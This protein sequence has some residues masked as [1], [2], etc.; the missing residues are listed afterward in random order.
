MSRCF[1]LHCMK[2]KLQTFLATRHITQWAFLNAVGYVLE[3][4]QL[5]CTRSALARKRHCIKK[6]G[7]AEN[8]KG[9]NAGLKLD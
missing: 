7:P 1:T 2:E 4:G 3:V 8:S 6:S 5:V 9:Q